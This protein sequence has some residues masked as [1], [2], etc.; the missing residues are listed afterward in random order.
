[1]Q[2]SV[3]LRTKQQYNSLVTTILS[4]FFLIASICC[5]KQLNCTLKLSQ[6]CVLRQ[7]AAAIFGDSHGFFF[8]SHHSIPDKRNL[9]AHGGRFPCGEC[10]SVDTLLCDFLLKHPGKK[11]AGALWFTKNGI[12][13]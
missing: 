8:L 13:E 1:M 12:R 11:P 3:F 7:I 10:V 4:H 5:V 9:S 6:N 2:Q